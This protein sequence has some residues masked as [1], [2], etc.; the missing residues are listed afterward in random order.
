MVI[1]KQKIKAKYQSGAKYYD[2]YVWLYRLIGFRI[3]AYR[4]R[5]I[6]LLHLQQRDCAVATAVGPAGI[7]APSTIH[8]GG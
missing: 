1:S 8:F 3:E 2:L 6:E 7:R 4:S 5:A